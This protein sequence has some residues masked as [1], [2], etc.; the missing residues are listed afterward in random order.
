MDP[1]CVTESERQCIIGAKA[2][3]DLSFTTAANIR[4]KREVVNDDGSWGL[5]EDSVFILDRGFD[6]EVLN[7]WNVHERRCSSYLL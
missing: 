4:E 1:N 2:T 5:N 6:S 7:E 3:R